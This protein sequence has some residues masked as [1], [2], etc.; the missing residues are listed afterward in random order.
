M[1]AICKKATLIVQTF[2]L[3]TM[4]LGLFCQEAKYITKPQHT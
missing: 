1:P 2:Y 3:G 4:P